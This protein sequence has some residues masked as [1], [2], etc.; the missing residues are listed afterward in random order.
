VTDFILILGGVWFQDFEIPP[1]VM[2]GGAQALFTHKYPGGARTVDTMGPDDDPI[3]WR[4]YFEGTAALPRCQQ[5]D[6]M[7]RQG[8]P[9]LLTWSAYQYLVVVRSFKWRFMR[10]YHYAYEIALEVVQDLTNPVQLTDLQQAELLLSD[11]AGAAAD[12]QAI[13]TSGGIGYD[14]VLALASGAAYLP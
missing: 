13:A 3:V 12:I 9:V 2:A 4:G 11:A 14:D 5:I 10:Y 7:R 8:Q 1:D 6:I